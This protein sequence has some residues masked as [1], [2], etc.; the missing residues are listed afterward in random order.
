[1]LILIFVYFLYLDINDQLQTTNANALLESKQLSDFLY[2]LSTLNRN[3][4]EVRQIPLIFNKIFE[5]RKMD[6]QTFAANITESSAFSKICSLLRTN[7]PQLDVSELV[8]CLKV[9]RS[10]NFQSDQKILQQILHHIRDQINELNLLQLVFVYLILTK[11]KPVPIVDALKIAIPIV[12]DLNIWKLDHENLNELQKLLH[13]IT[14]SRMKVSNKSMNSLLSSILLHG[15]SLNTS[16]AQSI[17]SSLKEFDINSLE[18]SDYI[19]KLVTNCVTVLNNNF[20]SSSFP[21]MENIL[22]KMIRKYKFSNWDVFYNET[23]FN[24]CAMSV[25]ENDLGFKTAYHVQRRLNEI[26]FVS[27]DLLNYIDRQIIQ[28]PTFLSNL[29]LNEL[30]TLINSF[31]TANYKS[32]NWDIIKSITLENPLIYNEISLDLPLLKFMCEMLS[33]DF[34]S[35]ILFDQILEKEFLT[36]YLKKNSLKNFA[37]LPQLRLVHQSLKLLHPEYDGNLPDLDIIDFAINAIPSTISSTNE[38]LKQMLE[39]IYGR[40]T[41]KTNV[42]TRYGHLLNFVMSFDSERRAILMPEHINYIEDFPKNQLCSIAIHPRKNCS[43]NYP[44]R[45]RG[46]MNLRKRTLE[47]IGIKE[48]DI[49]VHCLESLQDAEKLKFLEREI[50]YNLQEI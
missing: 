39:E 21:K 40:N 9:L 5:L 14:I 30:M 25:I 18:E 35:K 34:V 24:K 7:A 4:I 11:L 42:F 44:M 49:S 27:F 33:L 22:E 10:L 37:N 8:T 45:V 50:R 43:I 29:H 1:M 26:N 36:E 28:N 20:N 17:L 32:E 31:S 12:F 15:I 38:Y 48:I 2:R 41:V 16:E 13:I 23:F 3:A 46:V 19:E 6:S 47:A